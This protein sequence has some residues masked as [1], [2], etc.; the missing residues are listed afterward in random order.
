[1]TDYRIIA[2]LSTAYSGTGCLYHS[3]G[4]VVVWV[5]EARNR[6]E[7]LDRFKYY[8]MD[9]QLTDFVIALIKVEEV[10]KKVT[11]QISFDKNGG[12]IK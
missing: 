11:I 12:Q 3:S 7:A 6:S 2:K 5:V 10:S 8:I 1:M 9:H 4:L